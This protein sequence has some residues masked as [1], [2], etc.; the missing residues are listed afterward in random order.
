MADVEFE[1]PT[2]IQLLFRHMTPLSEN[3]RIVF[4]F[5]IC[6]RLYFY[7]LNPEAYLRSLPVLMM[8]YKTL[9]LLNRFK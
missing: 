8:S 6:I 1:I 7:L 5:P 9:L 2:L 4:P 3:I